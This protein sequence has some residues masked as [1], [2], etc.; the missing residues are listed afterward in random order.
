MLGEISFVAVETQGSIGFWF[1]AMLVSAGWGVAG[2][3][4]LHNPHR[5]FPEG[6]FTEG[7][8]GERI[9]RFEI[10]L[11]GTFMVFSGAAGVIFYLALLIRL[12][13]WLGL[14]TTLSCG[15]FAAIW[16]LKKLRQ[17]QS[18]IAVK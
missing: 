5:I 1:V 9:A 11:V 6:L 2:R 10:K 13:E 14:L 7:G 17:R 8:R 16:V 18:S 15:V 4:I 12:P 3:W